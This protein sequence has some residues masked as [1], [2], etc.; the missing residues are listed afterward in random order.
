MS[1]F[2]AT[3]Y[4]VDLTDVEWRVLRQHFQWGGPAR[5][6]DA[7]A[8][9]IGYSHAAA[10]YG[11]MRRL[12]DLVDGRQP[13]SCQDWHRLLVSAEILF[14]SDVIGCGVEWSIVS[15]MGDAET[16]VVLRG[17][18]RKLLALARG[19]PELANGVRRVD[20]EGT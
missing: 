3:R 9:V 1:V 19:M 18:Q 17:L 13:M 7:I 6:T 11:D 4:E 20:D 10:L 16:V 15:G 2:E 5:C 8:P 14:G 12:L